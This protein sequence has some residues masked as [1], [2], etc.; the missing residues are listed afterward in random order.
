MGVTNCRTKRNADAIPFFKRALELDANFAAAYASLGV[1]YSNLGQA[2]LAAENLKKAYALRDRV[3]E[4]EK[5]RISSMYYQL[6]SGELEQASQV[7]E[8]WA[9][10]Y[11]Q[12]FVPPGNLG[13][14]YSNLGQYD[15]ALTRTQ[16]GLRLE[17]SLVGYTNLAQDYLAP[18][19]LDDSKEALDQAQE[20]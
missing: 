18:N 6:V 9:K 16:E 10:S 11:P 5:Y 13:D 14:I 20:R 3:S 4:R 19:R 1:A 15:K 17:P 2:S 8:L 7:Y 12:D